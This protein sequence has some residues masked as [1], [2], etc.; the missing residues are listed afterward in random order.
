[1]VAICPVL[2]GR[3]RELERAGTLLDAAL[4]GAGGV[5]AVTGETG[6]GK[7]RLA[8]A[9]RERAESAGAA[10]AVGHCLEPFS[11]QPYAPVADLLR[12]ELMLG[13]PGPPDEHT[14]YRIAQRVCEELVEVARERPLLA[15]IEDLHWSDAATLELLPWLARRIQEQ[16]LLVVVTC[17]SDEPGG[18]L[19]TLGEL[20]RQRLCERV[21]LAGL[22]ADDVDEMIGAL[23]RDVPAELREAIGRRSG[24]NPLFVEELVGTLET[25]DDVPPSISEAVLRRLDRLPDDAR[26]LLR[27]ASVVGERFALEP[28]RVAAGL[29]EDAA[30]DAVRA[31]LAAQLVVED[32]DDGDFRFHH[33]LTRDAVYGS[34][35]VVERREA[36][37]RVAAALERP[38]E[39]AFHYEA[40]GDAERAREYARRAA[41]DAMA[42]GAL[43]DARRHVRTAL[44]LAWGAHDR[45]ELLEL[46]GA[47]DYALGHMSESE[48]AYSEA[49]ALHADVAD[50]ARALLGLALPLGM[51]ADRA[52]SL[53]VR[54]QALVLLEPLGDTAELA[55]AYR[56]IGHHHML[57]SAY[58]EAVRWS[59]RSIAIAEPLGEDTSDALVDLGSATIML[60]DVDRGVAF[61]RAAVP[62]PRAYV[63]LGDAL[64]HATRYAEAIEVCANGEARCRELGADFYLRLCQSNRAACLRFTGAWDE[65]ERLLEEILAEGEDAD[66]PKHR[67]MSLIVLAPLRADQGRWREAEEMCESLEP[68]ARNR[69]ELQHVQPL[70]LT[71]ARAKVAR[72]DTAGA[73]ADLEWLR[74][75][76]RE[77]TDDTV[78]IGPVLALGC[79]LGADWLGELE[80][81][82]ARSVSPETPILLAQARGEPTADAWERLGRPFDQARALRLAGDVASLEAARAI[83][84]RLGAAHELALTD[85]A[86]RQAGVR[87]ARGP[88]DSTRNAP[89][90]LTVREL[91]VARLVADG[92]TN[93]DVARA[94]VISDRTAAHHV[95]SILSKLRLTSRAQIA[96]WLVEHE[97]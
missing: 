94:L 67:L 39:I 18:A 56:S 27:A 88:R 48:A 20:E 90:G 61:L 3:E 23:G 64:C 30:L 54:R 21:A 87:V 10:T 26:T 17:R 95:S 62:S 60:G 75:Y 92:L 14:R 12:R 6:I 11:S 38:A 80:A 86:L 74:D 79:E 89:G 22:G 66:F 59:E 2:V 50:K 32:P 35:L 78:M 76:W 24:G 1:M 57:G 72:G 84:G 69:E 4:D 41:D 45:A 36:H 28:A 42:L 49:A 33:A 63:N 34:L 68:L 46:R 31:A 96:R 97:R 55:Q 37:A 25:S 73:L 83:F 51:T 16:P 81:M 19:A 29:D 13:A 82:A 70:R 58:G 5:V 52:R 65:A 44:R 47:I 91:E 77:H 9:L 15:V 53:S 71:R 93:A 8:G 7:T 43:S 85:A 40:A